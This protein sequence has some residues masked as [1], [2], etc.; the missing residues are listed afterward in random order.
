MPRAFNVVD[1][2]T[3]LQPKNLGQFAKSHRGKTT[4]AS[5]TQIGTRTPEP[6]AH[7]FAAPLR[8]APAPFMSQ[9][10]QGVGWTVTNGDVE[11]SPQAA[12]APPGV[13]C[14]CC[15]F[16]A[17]TLN[18]AAVQLEN[19]RQ[20][21]NDLFAKL[22]HA[23]AQVESLTTKLRVVQSFHV[24]DVERINVSVRLEASAAQARLSDE[25]N[26]E[27]ERASD[28]LARA[29]LA[30]RL[31]HEATAAAHVAQ[32]EATGTQTRLLDEKDA[33]WRIQ[34]QD[35][36]SELERARKQNED[37]CARLA[38]M[39]TKEK[40]ANYRLHQLET[41]LASADDTAA[42]LQAKVV[43][44]ES[45]RVDESEAST[46]QVDACG[47][48][49]KARESTSRKHIQKLERKVQQRDA[50]IVK[51]EDMAR[52]V[53]RAAVSVQLSGSSKSAQSATTDQSSVHSR[54][55][56]KKTD[57]PLGMFDVPASVHLKY[58]S[59]QHADLALLAQQLIV[60]MQTV[61]L[62]DPES[63]ATTARSTQPPM[64]RSSHALSAM[65][66]SSEEAADLAAI[67]R[68]AHPADLANR[69]KREERVQ[70]A[71]VVLTGVMQ[72]L[73]D[74]FILCQSKPS[75]AGYDK[76][77]YEL[78]SS[79]GAPSQLMSRAP[80]A[81]ETPFERELKLHVTYLLSRCKH[82]VGMLHSVLHIC[83]NTFEVLDR[84]R[85]ST[86]PFQTL[87]TDLRT[88]LHELRVDGPH[89]FFLQ[90]SVALLHLP[91][92]FRQFCEAHGAEHAPGDAAVSGD[93]AEA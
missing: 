46:D 25:K 14:A 60:L 34:V 5:W 76:S 81:P 83:L 67:A 69:V 66:A 88:F 92:A 15:A 84:E 19:S 43:E 54:A 58:K 51:L 24:Q 52:N 36:S 8:R 72:F 23:N 4:M 79:A 65:A 44:L 47:V 68:F 77:M 91:N 17:D 35:F 85:T 80:T 7:S 75:Q 9:W 3:N 56:P 10:I 32:L 62:N 53:P 42:A 41:E 59:L 26:A 87:I 78:C 11:Q 27:V 31:L 6:L 55:P 70:A 1:S 61:K 16:L 2:A 73:N 50:R 38:N 12:Q 74:Y 18:N 49:C 45:S 64:S 22:E 71:G 93:N 13:Q 20:Q 37:L 28:L 29:E 30:E 86:S 33:V 90:K 82:E 89:Y 57:V 63:A 39:T 48:A 21:T 40:Q